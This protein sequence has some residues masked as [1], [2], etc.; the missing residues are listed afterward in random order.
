MQLLTPRPPAEEEVTGLRATGELSGATRTKI[1][2]AAAFGPLVAGYALVVALFALVTALASLSHFSVLGVLRAAGPGLLAAYQ[3]PVTVTG[4]TLGVLP[5]LGTAVVGTFVAGSAAHAAGRLGYREPGQAVNVVAPIAATHALAGI[6][7]ALTVGS[8]RVNVEPLT[9]FLVPGFVSALCATAGVAK[10]CGILAAA[11]D[12]L[13]PLALRGLRAGALGLA[14]L[15]GVGAVVYT[16]TLGV[17][18]RTVGHLF[19]ANAPGF[20]SGAGMLLLSIGYLPNAVIA[21]LSFVAGPGFSIGSVSLTPFSYRGG[22]LPGLPLLANMPEH[23]ARWWPALLVLPAAVGVLVGWSLRRSDED[24]RARLRTV[25]IA[26]ALIG[27]G[28]VLL[29]TLAGGQLG[30][31]PFNPVSVPVGLLSVAAF[32]WIAVPGGLVAWLAGPRRPAP[33]P[34]PVVVEEPEPEAESQDE[35][36]EQREPD[37]VEEPDDTEDTE[38][39]AAVEDSEDTETAEDA[40]DAEEPAQASDEAK[41]P[42]S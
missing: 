11:R 42:G 26:G 4:G 9:A 28:C 41:E 23:A 31:G 7:I 20:G 15:L 33:A 29:G 2:F 25:G 6:T 22:T 30:H 34:E 16:V 19:A 40:E 8:V 1:V 21:T 37:T 32:G 39:T 5:L 38:D 36:D 18:V 24:P 35:A 10:R 12:H 3:V 17:S 27:F 13:D 14:G